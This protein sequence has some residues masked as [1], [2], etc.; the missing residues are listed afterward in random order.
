MVTLK[1]KDKTAHIGLIATMPGY[2]GKGLGRQLIN[3][4]IKTAI[5]NNCNTLEVATQFDNKQ[6]CSFY[7]VCN[8]NVL[9]ITNIYH[10]WL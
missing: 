9:S 8:F 6:A 1:I 4:C 10:L 7:Q 5:G 3:R 2:Q